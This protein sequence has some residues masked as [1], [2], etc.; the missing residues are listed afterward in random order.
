M[1]AARRLA[2][3]VLMAALVLGACARVQG[4][5]D[6]RRALK[7]AGYSDVDVSLETTGVLGFVTVELSTAGAPRLERA[8][9]VV[10]DTLPVRFYT[11]LFAVDGQSVSYTYDDLQ[12]LFGD[13]DPSLDR[14]QVDEEVVKSGLKLM[15]LL[16]A[17]AVA[18]VGVVVALGLP[19]LRAA[20]RV[21]RGA[22]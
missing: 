10:W 3:P 11:L 17:G 5:A 2:V 9:E 13:R 18:S 20:R 14:R 21:R 4:V 19:A 8:A 16:T 12:G 15:L 22:P 6:T 1:R 7:H